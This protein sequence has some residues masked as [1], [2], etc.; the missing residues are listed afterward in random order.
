M[1]KG[2]VYCVLCPSGKQMSLDMRLDSGDIVAGFHKVKASGI[3]IL[4][5][6]F[7]K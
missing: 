1:E 2:V 7:T 4:I 3:T 5:G 6:R